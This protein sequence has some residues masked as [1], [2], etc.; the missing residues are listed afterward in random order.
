MVPEQHAPRL[1]PEYLH[2]YPHIYTWI[3][4]LYIYNCISAYLRV[5]LHDTCGPV[6]AH[7]PLRQTG[8]G[9]SRFAVGGGAQRGAG[10]AA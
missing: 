4:I 2:M 5:G 6:I 8:G 10:G 3:Y 7:G 9:R 1:C